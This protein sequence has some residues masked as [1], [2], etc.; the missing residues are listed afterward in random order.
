M[1]SE[2]HGQS[3]FSRRNE[4]LTGDERYIMSNKSHYELNKK[5]LLTKA[6]TL[7][8]RKGY[9][10]TS[11]RDIAKAYGCKPANIYNYFPAKEDMLYEIL[12]GAVKVLIEAIK[13]FEE[14][15]SI[16]P[17]EQLRLFIKEHV[18]I[19]LS[20]IRSGKWLTDAGLAEMKP[21]KREKI[22]ELR[23]TYD[24]ILGKIIQKNIDRGEFPQTDVKLAVFMI[25]SM[26]LRTRIWYSP[27][28]RLSQEEIGE[29]IFKFALNGLRGESV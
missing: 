20:V 4:I 6:R 2:N 10:E 19:A 18:K 26:I 27:R 11:M 9:A 8:W 22:I 25:S 3:D 14:D 21:A 13:H 5:K 16:N 28:G 7:F 12:Y 15:D 29:F 17:L 23:D 24:R 1:Y